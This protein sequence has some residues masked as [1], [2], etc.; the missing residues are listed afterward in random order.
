[1]LFA[2]GG[3]QEQKCLYRGEM[4]AVYDLSRTVMHLSED[5]FDIM[6]LHVGE[7]SERDRSIC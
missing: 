4:Q 7:R 6:A 2:V 3:I 1:M 5:L